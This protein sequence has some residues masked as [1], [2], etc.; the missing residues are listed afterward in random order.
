MFLKLWYDKCIPQFLIAYIDR[1]GGGGVLKYPCLVL[2]HDDTVVQ[3]EATV[4]YP[5]FVEF[6]KAYRPGMSITLHEYISG[7]YDPGYVPMCKERFAFTDEELLIEYNGWKEYIRNHIPAP[8]PGIER[9]IRT[10]K[11]EGGIIC[12][13]SQSSQENISR[14]YEAHF[15]IQPDAIFGWDLQPEHR[16]PSPWALDQI[17]KTYN[18]SPAELLVIDDMKTAISM[19]RS[20]GCKIAFAGWGRR[21]YPQIFGEM[22]TLCD[23]SFDSIDNLETF[24]FE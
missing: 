17:M 18:L 9:I 4:N 23:F 20:G 15:G 1:N 21:E 13:V 10:Q 5:F 8:Y 16:K 11:A 22:S 7:C 6:L 19:A 24:L 3:S 12:V 14:D 2:D